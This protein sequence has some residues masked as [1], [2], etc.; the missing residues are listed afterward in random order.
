[1]KRVIDVSTVTS[2]GALVRRAGINLLRNPMLLKSRVT[3]SIII[4]VY[5]GGLYWDDGRDSYTNIS[6]AASILGFLFCI[7]ISSLMSALGPVSLIFPSE[8]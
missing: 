1:M 3:Q 8:R 2:F 7:T 4:G 5:L 6:D